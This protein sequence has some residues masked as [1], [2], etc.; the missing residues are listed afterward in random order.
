MRAAAAAEEIVAAST[1]FHSSTRGPAEQAVINS[2]RHSA[3]ATSTCTSMFEHVLLAEP[4]LPAD[5]PAAVAGRTTRDVR[6]AGCEPDCM[7]LKLLA[8]DHKAASRQL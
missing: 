1:A 3:K 2:G 8:L 7:L 6:A 5:D 4:S